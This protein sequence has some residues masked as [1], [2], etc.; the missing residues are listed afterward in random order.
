MLPQVCN[1]QNGIRLTKLSCP[2]PPPDSTGLI[3]QELVNLGQAAGAPSVTG[4]RL[5]QKHLPVSFD[6]C[7][8]LKIQACFPLPPQTGRRNNGHNLCADFN[9]QPLMQKFPAFLD[10]QIFHGLALFDCEPLVNQPKY[11]S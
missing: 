10:R 2:Q 11:L 4:H 5:I 3:I 8:V 9:N 6:L 7:P 1:I